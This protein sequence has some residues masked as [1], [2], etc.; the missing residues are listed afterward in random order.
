MRLDDLLRELDKKAQR[1]GDLSDE[2][3]LHHHQPL[4]L[5]EQSAVQELT[6]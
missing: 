3:W 1:M 5:R 6:C 2:G 4:D